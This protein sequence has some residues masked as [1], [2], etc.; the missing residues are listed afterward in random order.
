MSLED[1]PLILQL[2]HEFGFLKDYQSRKFAAGYG[3][4][5]FGVAAS[6][7]DERRSVARNAEDFMNY[8][9]NAD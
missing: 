4:L 1:P 2:I 6:L 5:R 9:A 3:D 7:Q 8:V